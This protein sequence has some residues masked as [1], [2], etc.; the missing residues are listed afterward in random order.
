MVLEIACYA[1]A[2]TAVAWAVWV[3]RST[4]S[5]P[6]ER[7]T[8]SAIVQLG[9][10]LVLIAPATQPVFGRLLWEVTGKWH[11]AD[12]L[13][14]MLALGA[15]V[16]TNLAGLIR[17]PN[18]RRHVVPLLWCPLVAG[19][20]VL[21]QLFC[22]SAV[23]RNPGHD[24]FQLQPDW[25]LTAYYVLLGALIAYYGILN[26]WIALAHLRGDPRARPV[27]LAWLACAGITTLAAAALLISML[28]TTAWYD[29]GRLA[30]CATVTVY[31]VASAR[32]WQRKLDQWRKLITGTGARI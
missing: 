4:F 10:A 19:T 23:T 21:M 30:M 24:L 31:A 6:W 12:M 22:H 15:M 29:Y 28:R 2:L 1:V 27:A 13:G 9:L 26:A 16:S 25:W 3:R 8:T 7:T 14:H 17:M 32:S 18:M 20:A 5:N 11:L